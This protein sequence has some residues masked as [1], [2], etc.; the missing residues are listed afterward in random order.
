M[1]KITLEIEELEE[2]IAPQFFAILGH[3]HANAAYFEDGGPNGI[4]NNSGFHA[5]PAQ[6]HHGLMTASS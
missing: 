4:L 6:A 1:R 3:G 5:M 2:R